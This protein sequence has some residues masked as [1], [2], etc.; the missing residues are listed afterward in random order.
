MKKESLCRSTHSRI[1]GSK[2]GEM[3]TNHTHLLSLLGLVM[4][5][6][7]RMCFFSKIPSCTHLYA[8]FFKAASGAGRRTVFKNKAENF[9]CRQI[10]Q[11]SQYDNVKWN[12]LPHILYKAHFQNVCRGIKAP[13][14]LRCAKVDR[15]SAFT[16]NV[17][18]KN[19]ASPQDTDKHWEVR[20][21]CARVGKGG[22]LM[23]KW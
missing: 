21:L 18:M 9:K 23:W 2:R 19:M 4:S 15:C 5:R 11:N 22:W 6:I 3:N 7:S 17:W 13:P 16:E 1:T 8:V 14:L 12:I 10:I 20:S